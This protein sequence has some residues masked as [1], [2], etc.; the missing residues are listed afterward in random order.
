MLILPFSEARRVQFSVL[1]GL[2]GCCEEG[3]SR[4]LTGVSHNLQTSIGHHVFFITLILKIEH[5]LYLLGYRAKSLIGSLN[6]IIARI[7][8]GRLK[9]VVN[10]LVSQCQII[11]I[12]K[13][14]IL[15]EVLTVNEIIDLVKKRGDKCFLQ[16]VDFKKAYDSVSWEFLN[17]ML[18][19]TGFSD[20]WRGWTKACMFSPFMSFL[21]NGSTTG[22]FLAQRG[23]WRAVR[24]LLF[25]SCQQQRLGGIGIQCYSQRFVESLLDER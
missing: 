11:F 16:K 8:F 13:R 7:L 23:L 17:Y 18:T 2:L 24:W 4:A 10:K 25:C 6:K 21:V 3:R 5:P 1:Q 22:V 20:L 15:D 14:R 12:A 19:R 9:R